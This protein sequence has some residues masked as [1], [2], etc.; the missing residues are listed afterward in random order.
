MVKAPIK[1]YEISPEAKVVGLCMICIEIPI[2]NIL[3]DKGLNTK[4]NIP[5]LEGVQIHNEAGKI[6]TIKYVDQG[7]NQMVKQRQRFNPRIKNTCWPISSE[8]SHQKENLL[9]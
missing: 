9:S 3:S 5:V 6:A 8:K 7:Q 2:F 1:I 4:T